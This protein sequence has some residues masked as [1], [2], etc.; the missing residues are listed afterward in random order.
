MTHPSEGSTPRYEPH[1]DKQELHDQWWLMTLFAALIPFGMSLAISLKPLEDMLREDSAWIP[2]FSKQDTLLLDGALLA[3]SVIAPIFM[4]LAMDVVWSVNLAVLLC[5]IGSVMGSFFVAMGFAWYSFGLALTGRVISGFCFGS[6]FVVSDIIACQF[7]RKR[8]GITLASICGVKSLALFL[9]T[10]WMRNF[11]IESLGGDHEKMH[12]ILLISSLLCLGVGFL[13]APLVASFNMDDTI[14][15]RR[16]GWKWHV[17]KST[18]GLALC[19]ILVGVFGS[20]TFFDIQSRSFPVM[21]MSSLILGPV[22]GYWMDVTGKS[23]DGSAWVV[24]LSI[25]FT[26]ILL[27]GQML[28]E[29]MQLDT[30]I[31]GVCLGI[32]PMLL[33]L[34]IPQVSRRDNMCTS[35]GLME[36]ASFLTGIVVNDSLPVSF[37]NQLIMVAAL[38]FLLTFVSYSVK[39]KW[40]GMPRSYLVEPLHVRGA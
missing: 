36:S 12:D 27:G 2:A 15:T 30:G 33:R 19:M 22:L 13:W 17:G 1:E 38:V 3:P 31:S 28:Q 8:K 4:G 24:N 29:L 26:W 40:A 11:T 10:Y 6:I 25:A 34:T 39:E 37:L 14:K 5:L 20:Y 32:L 35:F 9:N 7:N 18:W 16:A 21:M 23:Q